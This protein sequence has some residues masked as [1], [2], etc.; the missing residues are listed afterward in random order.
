[1]IHLTWTGI[2]NRLI[3]RPTWLIGQET[4]RTKTSQV[5]SVERI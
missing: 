4:K 2:A 1:M 3:I 5:L